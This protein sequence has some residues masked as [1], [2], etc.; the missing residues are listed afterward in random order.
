M[1]GNKTVDNKRNVD[2]DVLGDDILSI[3]KFYYEDNDCKERNIIKYDTLFLYAKE[4]TLKLIRKSESNCEI[5]R[6]EFNPL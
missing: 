4:T 3:S 6:F 5:P 1:T 2:N